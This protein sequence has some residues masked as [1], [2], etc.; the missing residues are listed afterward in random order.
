M[1]LDQHRGHLG[2]PWGLIEQMWQ[3]SQGQEWKPRGLSPS[4]E[5]GEKLGTWSALQSSELRSVGRVLL[6]ACKGPGSMSSAPCGQ[7]GP[8]A[9]R[10]PTGVQSLGS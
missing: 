9:G 3:R 7:L 1:K 10:Q 6:A 2:E 8:V 4:L 5:G